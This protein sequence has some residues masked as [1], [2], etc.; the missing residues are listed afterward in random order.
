MVKS[1]AKQQEHVTCSLSE[2]FSV[3]LHHQVGGTAMIWTVV[4]FVAWYANSR[5]CLQAQ[6]LMQGWSG[7]MATSESDLMMFRPTKRFFRRKQHKA[8]RK[9][10]LCVFW[11]KLWKEA[12]VEGGYSTRHRPFFP[13]KD[14]SVLAESYSVLLASF[15]SMDSTT[16]SLLFTHSDEDDN[17]V[18]NWRS[19]TYYWSNI[20]F[21]IFRGFLVP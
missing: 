13:L 1:D 7:K 15:V 14:L 20:K 5:C 19:A 2:M 4:L 8:E 11:L 6:L 3:T 21:I 16:T 17:G 12:V 18:L 9:K 10:Q